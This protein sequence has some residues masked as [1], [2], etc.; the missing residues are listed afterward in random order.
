MFYTIYD[1]A[2]GERLCSTYL[3][4]K[5]TI[6]NFIQSYVKDAKIIK[7]DTENLLLNQYFVYDNGFDIFSKKCQ[8]I[9]VKAEKITNE[10]IKNFNQIQQIIPLATTGNPNIVVSKIKSSRLTKVLPLT[11]SISLISIERHPNRQILSHGTQYWI[12]NSNVQNK[13]L[14]LVSGLDFNNN[15]EIIVSTELKNSFYNQI[16]S[17]YSSR[18]S[19]KFKQYI[20]PQR[21][22][23][24][25]I[26]KY[27]D[28]FCMEHYNLRPNELIQSLK[29]E[30]YIP[31][32][33]TK[34][35]I[36]IDQAILVTS[37]MQLPK[38]IPI[39][40]GK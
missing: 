14:R 27:I 5:K 12:Y 6:R 34:P 21:I 16:N 38:D 22:I 24:K 19:E 33:K 30:N 7:E 13:T 18:A 11:D 26:P 32:N 23:H 35:S 9:I 10:M 39:I 17:K 8:N 1:T 3:F 28:D 40:Y 36:I 20:Q 2:D 4:A 15:L 31:I 37:E 29:L 25:L